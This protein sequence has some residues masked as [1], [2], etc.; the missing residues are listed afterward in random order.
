MTMPNLEDL[1]S[2]VE[3]MGGDKALRVEENLGQGFVRLRVAEAERRQAAHD[4]RHS[5]DIVIELLRNARDAGA[6]HVF[7]ATTKDA[8]R[9]V[10]T[11][12]DDGAGIPRELWDAVFEARVTSKLE[13]VHMDRWGV[14]GRGMALYSVRQNTVSAEVM[15]S[16][17]GGGTSLRVESDT[18]AL[19]E[20]AD[21]STWPVVGRTDAGEAVIERG[22]HNIVRTCCEFA[23]EEHGR[24][25]VYLGSP[26]EIAATICQRIR[27]GATET[28]ALFVRDISSLPV[29]E[30][31]R[32][33]CDAV[34]LMGIART[35][36][37]AMSERTAQR[38]ISGQIRPVQ[39]VYT[40]LLHPQEPRRQRGV[41]LDQDRRG[42]RLSDGDMQEFVSLMERDFAYLAER[43]Y[44]TL[45][46]KPRVRV[47]GNRLS[48]FFDCEGED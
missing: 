19:P 38:I 13:S 7:V 18:S 25:E 46:T 22:P 9:R 29:L 6:R 11:I 3:R 41:R 15:D 31:F 5:E 35:C 8:D 23:L 39:S 4:I 10:I 21:Q 42:L 48:V 28:D 1:T 2:F 43:Y 26:A 44:L 14:H 45:T 37:L 20:R 16:V 30:R 34:E 24:C 36:G 47:S 40:R 17:V 32:H 33:A 12:L 27:S